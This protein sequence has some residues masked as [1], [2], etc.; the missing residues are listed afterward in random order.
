MKLLSSSSSNIQQSISIYIYKKRKKKKKKKKCL[1]G[2]GG[3]DRLKRVK[4][5]EQRNMS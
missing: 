3:V 5:H 2:K 4:G 1:K